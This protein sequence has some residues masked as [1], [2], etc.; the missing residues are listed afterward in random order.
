MSSIFGDVLA[1]RNLMRGANRATRDFLEYYTVDSIDP[2]M[3]HRLVP[4]SPADPIH[5]YE[6]LEV[7]AS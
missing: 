4:R 2:T 7:I 3:T 1:R 5:V 6:P